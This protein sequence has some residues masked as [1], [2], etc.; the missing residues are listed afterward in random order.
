M[1][2]NADPRPAAGTSA[3]AAGA[4]PGKKVRSKHHRTVM[5]PSQRAI[6]GVLAWIDDAETANR[7]WARNLLAVLAMLVVLL[8]LAFR[9]GLLTD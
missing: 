2:E 9:T 8:L 7:T 1:A 6:T 3:E 5:A 4:G